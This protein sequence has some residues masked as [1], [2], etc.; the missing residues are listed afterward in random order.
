DLVKAPEPFVLCAGHPGNQIAICA[1]VALQPAKALCHIRRP[2]SLAE[3][4]ITGEVDADLRLP[5]HHLGDRGR[6]EAVEGR[7]IVRL[8][9]LD[10]AHDVDNLA[11]AHQT[12]SMRGED[13]TYA[14]L[15]GAL[16]VLVL[17]LD[18]ATPPAGLLCIRDL[19]SRTV[20]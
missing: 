8:A 14:T 11:W 6:Q 12:A 4:A 5:A 7:G 10:L 13:M 1:L 16:L 18:D 9:G 17:L 2:A 20:C 19:R 15:H 3:L